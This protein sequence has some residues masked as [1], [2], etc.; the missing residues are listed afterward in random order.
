VKATTDTFFSKG[1][2]S[3]AGFLLDEKK[4]KKQ[5]TYKLEN[6]TTLAATLP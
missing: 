6:K 3:F 1:D 5:R 4:G 2:K